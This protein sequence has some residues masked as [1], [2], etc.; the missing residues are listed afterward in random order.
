MSR[1]TDWQIAEDNLFEE[2]GF[3]ALESRDLKLRGSMM[4]A[5]IRYLERHPMTQKEAAKFFNV[6]QPRISNLYSGKVDL[7][8]AG[9][10]LAMLD[11]AGFDIYHYIESYLLVDGASL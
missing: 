8:S 4:I 9:M 1:K 5:L 11:K 6:S 3:S 2:L 7:F 10:L